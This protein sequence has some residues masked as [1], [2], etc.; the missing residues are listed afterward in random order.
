V[1]GGE[2]SGR[3]N[4][5]VVDYHAGVELSHCVDSL[6]ANGVGEIVVVNNAAIGASSPDLRGREVTLVEPG[7]NVGY[8]RGVN[9]GAAAAS[10]RELLVISNAD[11][12]VHEGAIATLVEY[13]DAHAD[14]GIV[15]PRIM[16]SA[17]R[18]Y[19]SVRIF[20]DPLVA[21]LHALC[22]P[23]WPANPWTKKYRSPGVNGRVDWVSGAF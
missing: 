19:P 18:T 13:L 2:L 20:P 14:V 4:A 9:R 10:L 8:G 3:V 5:V 6:L 22:A 15:G 23:W 21:L 17:G 7:V 16:T 11:V 1:S 12:T